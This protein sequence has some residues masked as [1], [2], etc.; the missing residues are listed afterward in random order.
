MK[1][2]RVCNCEIIEKREKYVHIEDYDCGEMK[3]DSWWHLNCFKKAMNRE[4]TKLEKQAGFLLNKIGNIYQNLPEEL[5]P[6][7]VYTI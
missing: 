5:K 2:C 1:V 7:E 6:K 4:P 3:G